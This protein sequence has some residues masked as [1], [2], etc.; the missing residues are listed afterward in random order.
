MVWSDIIDLLLFTYHV[1]APAVIL[2]VCVGALSRE[3]SP[4]L[5]KSVFITMLVASAA[6]F[7]YRLTPYRAEFDPAVFGVLASCVV[8]FALRLTVL[9][10]VTNSQAT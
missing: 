3:R 5:N 6:T 2:P 1:W 7:A 10:P 4:Q 9:R 8:F